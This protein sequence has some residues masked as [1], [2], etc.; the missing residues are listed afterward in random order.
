MFRNII[1]RLNAMD[2]KLSATFRVYVQKETAVTS[3]G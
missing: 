1:K 2:G 3:F